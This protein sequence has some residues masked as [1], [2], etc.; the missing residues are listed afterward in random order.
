[1]AA[2]ELADLRFAELPSLLRPGDLLVVN[3]SRVLPARL[4]G[5]KATGGKVELLLERELAPDEALVQLRASHPPPVG[6]R[7][8]FGEGVS[9]EMLGRQDEFFHVRF[10][11]PVRAVFEAQGHVPLPPYIRRADVPA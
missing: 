8:I 2:G 7:L 6:S 3:D 10:D 5:H 4:H 1:P 11:R 9:A